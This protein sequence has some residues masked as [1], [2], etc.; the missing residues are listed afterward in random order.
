MERPDFGKVVAA[1]RT[2]EDFSV[3]VKSDVKIIFD[4]SPDILV[5][6]KKVKIAHEAGKKIFVHIDLA[7]GIGKDESGIKYV[8]AVG[9]D[10]I[11]STRV[12]IV[13][14]ARENDMFA[15]QRFFAVDSQSIDTTISAIKAAKPDMIEIMPGIL[16]K[17]IE[18]LCEKTDIPIIAG[19]LIDSADE[20]DKAIG[21]GATAVSTGK[22]NL[23][24]IK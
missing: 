10:G 4:L 2:L 15:V 23:W 17:V 3:A 21:N 19:G 13:R 6:A 7:S 16:F 22:K 1:V 24:G 5:L 9:V 18:S 14:I 11:I 12:N 20:I 8:K